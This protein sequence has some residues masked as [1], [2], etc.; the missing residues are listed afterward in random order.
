MLGHKTL[1]RVMPG[2]HSGGVMGDPGAE[3]LAAEEES[4]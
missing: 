2:C 3:Y 1:A 4:A